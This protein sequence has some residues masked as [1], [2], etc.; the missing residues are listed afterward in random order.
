[1]AERQDR[2]SDR[3][4]AFAVADDVGGRL[5]SGYGAGQWVRDGP[6]PGGVAWSGGHSVPDG[7]GR[8]SDRGHKR[9]GFVRP[10][11]LPLGP[12]R[13]EAALPGFRTYVQTGIVLEVGRI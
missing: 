6:E 7:D 11:S 4:R 13:V 2:I 10:T 9:D 8:G 1:M 3:G 12:Y 5:G